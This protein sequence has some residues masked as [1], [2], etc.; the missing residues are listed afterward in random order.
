MLPI[1]FP[2]VQTLT[3]NADDLELKKQLAEFYKRVATIYGFA[4]DK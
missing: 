1:V 3:A 2:G 4:G